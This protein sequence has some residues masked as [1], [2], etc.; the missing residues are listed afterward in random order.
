MRGWVTDNVPPACC[1]WMPNDGLPEVFARVTS[2]T[3]P[4]FRTQMPADT[5]SILEPARHLK[6]ALTSTLG[7]QRHGSGCMVGLNAIYPHL[8][9][10]NHFLD[11]AKENR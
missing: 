3:E 5:K 8:D 9:S 7:Q 1:A 11:S 2:L 4:N 6:L 10:I